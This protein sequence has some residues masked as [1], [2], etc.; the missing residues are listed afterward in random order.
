MVVESNT[1]DEVREVP[2]FPASIDEGPLVEAEQM[3]G[4][5][6]EHLRDIF[7]AA[8]VIM[9]PYRS[10]V[11]DVRLSAFLGINGDS[12]D[13][14]AHFER[15]RD[16]HI[17]AARLAAACDPERRCASKQPREA[18]SFTNQECTYKC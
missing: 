5:R 14:I 4:L 9:P 11:G 7:R 1:A 8:N 13:T 16:Q 17:L 10:D 2:W 6:K 3:R 12:H 15:V 18:Q